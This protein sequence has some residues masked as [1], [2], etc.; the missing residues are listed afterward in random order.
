MSK[1]LTTDSQHKYNTYI[2]QRDS[3]I[4]GNIRCLLLHFQEKI[5]W[6]M[7]LLWKQESVR[8]ATPGI[9]DWHSGKWGASQGKKGCEVYFSHMDLM[10]PCQNPYTPGKVSG[11]VY[12][13]DPQSSYP[14][15]WSIN[16]TSTIYS[17]SMGKH[18]PLS[19]WHWYGLGNTPIGKKR[20]ELAK[21]GEETEDNVINHHWGLDGSIYVMGLW[22]CRGYVAFAT[23]NRT[24]AG[25]VSQGRGW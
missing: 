16:M 4:S 12:P 9:L 6:R 23:L 11:R 20:K 7:W 21:G 3:G 18:W 25:L 24:Q 8:Q 14:W 15:M 1:E 10:L 13:N 22:V 19:S 2:C 17:L 5:L